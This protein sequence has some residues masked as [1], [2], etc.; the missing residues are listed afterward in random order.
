MLGIALAVKLTT[1]GPVFFRQTRYGL[2]GKPIGVLKFRSMTTADDGKVVKQA[3]KDDKRI[4]PIGGFL[5]KS[6]L[7]ELPQFINVVLGQMSIVG[8]RPT[9]LPTT[10]NTA[11]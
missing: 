1:K 11:V 2:N 9:P 7:D 4:T 6:S 8:P 3:T 5:R 10:N